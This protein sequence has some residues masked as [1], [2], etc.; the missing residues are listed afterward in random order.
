MQSIFYT[1]LNTFQAIQSSYCDV[2]QEN[3]VLWYQPDL[4]IEGTWKSM[5]GI[6][7]Q[8]CKWV[9]KYSKFKSENVRTYF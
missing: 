7:F 8:L 1:A 3:Q 6:H 4:K 2:N 9:Q 5:Q